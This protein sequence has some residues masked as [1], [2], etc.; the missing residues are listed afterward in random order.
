M[1]PKHTLA[2]EWANCVV[3]RQLRPFRINLPGN[4]KP[5]QNPP[6]PPQRGDIFV[7]FT[8][9][10]LMLLGAERRAAHFS[11]FV[12]RYLST[13]NAVCQR[14]CVQLK[15]SRTLRIICL[16]QLG[17]RDVGAKTLGSRDR[18]GNWRL[19]KINIINENINN[20][21]YILLRCI[22]QG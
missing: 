4:L 20:G 12:G 9:V 11:V 21:Y 3:V 7:A 15:G 22:L 5:I 14:F 13:G 8:W 17:F 16:Q 1:R 6:L 19:V 10:T 2:D 18:P